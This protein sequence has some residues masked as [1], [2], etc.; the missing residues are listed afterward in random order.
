MSTD[1]LAQKY[2]ADFPILE[3]RVNGHPLVYLDN[4]ASTQHPTCVIDEI[5]RY[6]RE[7]H[8]NVHRGIHELSSR[9]TRLYEDARAQIARFIG[10]ES[11]DS[12]IFTRGTTEGINLVATAWGS[13]RLRPGDVILITEMEHHA[14][15][16]PWQILARRTG[17]LLQ[18]LPVQGDEGSIDWSLLERRLQEAPVRILAFTHISNVLACLNP[19]NEICAIAR[20]NGV[21]T[22]VDAAQSAGHAPINVQEIG[23]DFLVFSGHKCCGPTGIGVLYG[24]REVLADMEPYQFGGEMI[25]RVTYETAEWKEGPHRFEAGTPHI[26]GAIG[27]AAALAYLD[28]VGRRA[29]QS[30]DHRL[31]QIGYQKLSTL[32]GIR[33]LG[34]R[35]DRAG[36]VSFQLGSI[37]AHDL[38]AYANEFGIALRGGHHCA[39]PLMRKL[40]LQATARASFYFYNRESEIDRLI[41]VMQ[42][43]IRYFGV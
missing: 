42:R 29:I 37:H 30:T 12:I 28:R 41:E 2:R 20:K 15:L 22:L 17:A 31:G 3:Q 6:Y 1:L 19:A 35:N 10:A 16:I 27:L 4:A 18:Y 34:P 33:I 38:V 25:S 43:S 5:A 11:Q 36:L 24:N 8:A 32:P 21:L 26:A 40:G 39:Q 14:N 7:D 13:P 23:C 9:A